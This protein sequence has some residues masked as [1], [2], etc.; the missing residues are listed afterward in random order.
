MPVP[1]FV[2]QSDVC[3]WAEIIVLCGS[4]GDVAAALFSADGLSAGVCACADTKLRELYAN[5]GDGGSHCSH[6]EE[7][8]SMEV[9][10]P[11]SR[12][13]FFIPEG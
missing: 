12:A 4:T 3:A 7:N 10:I 6:P 1:T 8:A 2:I 5:C 13:G 9:A 11:N